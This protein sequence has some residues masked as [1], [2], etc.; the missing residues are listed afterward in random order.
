MER[1]ADTV[2]TGRYTLGGRQVRIRGVQLLDR[3]GR[4][5]ALFTNGEP[6][7]IRILWEG[8]VAEGK[9]YAASRLD[10]DVHYGVCAFEARDPAYF[11]NGGLPLH[12]QGACEFQIPALHLGPGTYHV[13]CALWRFRVPQEKE[14]ILHY[15][16][17]AV[18]FSVQSADHR[19]SAALYEP[20][21]VFQ[22]LGAIHAAAK[23]G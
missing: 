20:P 23:A 10:S 15:L 3:D 6:L 1:L 17:R 2:A 7:R 5:R 18:Q 14:D 8:D 19:A 22:D 21:M 4:E 16:E 11:L 13:S 12:G 9:V